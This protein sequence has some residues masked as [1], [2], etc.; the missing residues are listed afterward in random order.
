MDSS[1]R[2]SNSSDSSR[3]RNNAK[4]ATVANGD[5]RRRSLPQLVYLVQNFH[6]VVV[7]KR[8]LTR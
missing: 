5:A 7:G 6:L 4:V 8:Q 1:L 2:R 3:I